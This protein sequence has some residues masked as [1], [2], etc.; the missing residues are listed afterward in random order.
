M[1]VHPTPSRVRVT[2]SSGGT[3]TCAQL[4]T[5]PLR[6]RKGVLKVTFTRPFQKKVTLE[7]AL[8]G[9]GK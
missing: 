5:G 7:L 4:E 8:E 9:V 1:A 6:F 2:Y 3:L